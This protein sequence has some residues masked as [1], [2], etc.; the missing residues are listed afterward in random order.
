MAA[1]DWE[2]NMKQTL[3]ANATVLPMTENALIRNCNILVEG[4]KIVALGPG[5]SSGTAD[6][7]DCSGLYAVPG[8]IEAHAHI[9]KS[10]LETAFK[11]YIANGV[12][13]FRNMS[14]NMENVPGDGAL[15]TCELKQEI[16]A[17]ARIAPTLVNTSNIF[18]GYEPH[19]QGSYV[20]TTIEM[21]RKFIKEAIAQGADQIKVYEELTPE[22]FDEIHRLAQEAG[23]KVVG[24]CPVRVDK[25]VF[26]SKAFSYEHTFNLTIDDVPTVIQHGT[27]WVPTLIVES[28]YDYLLNQKYRR[29]MQNWKY[30]F[31]PKDMSVFWEMI[32]KMAYL[33]KDGDT[34]KNFSRKK[35]IEKIRRFHG[36]G[37]LIAV[38]TDFPNPFIY[39]GF[40]MYYEFLMLK[41]CGLSNF[42]V[43]KAATINGAKVLEIA[44]R[45]GTLEAGKDADI[46]FLRSNPL[47]SIRNARKIEKVVLR[48]K[49]FNKPDLDHLLHEAAVAR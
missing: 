18:D 8:Y 34:F 23:L 19:Q 41:K 31:V 44:D 14:G 2:W 29:F 36:L 32:G 38:G 20:V 7:I 35:A 15:D 33:M 3:Y 48:G 6:R 30:R 24:H 17:G 9:I 4:K 28:N 27:Y 11:A 26:F 21:A 42:E 43:L 12:T 1:R 16:E 40:S 39:P 10:L 5:L 46:V 45:K 25:N 47:L 49:L 22:I 13:S 37:G